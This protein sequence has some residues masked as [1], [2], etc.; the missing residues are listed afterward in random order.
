MTE[1]ITVVS[2]IL[3]GLILIV[4][5]IIFVPG[6]TIVG[7]IGCVFLLMGIVFSFSYFGAETGWITI[8]VTSVASGLILY[9]AFKANFWSRFSLKSTSD[10]KVNEGEFDSIVVGNEGQAIS[11]L[12]PVGKAE[13]NG[14]MYEVKSLGEYV[15]SGK[16]V[17]ILKIEN[18]QILVQPI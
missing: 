1:W 5:E 6:I 16:K 3:F 14:K 12:R 8:G 10:S 17:R 11:A 2:L 15:E 7:I 4:A 18:G 13:I 9:Y